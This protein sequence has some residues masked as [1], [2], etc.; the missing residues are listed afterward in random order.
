MNVDKIASLV[1]LADNSKSNDEI[2]SNDTTNLANNN[3]C[4]DNNYIVAHSPTIPNKIYLLPRKR[5]RKVSKGKNHAQDN[6]SQ[7]GLPTDIMNIQS[8]DSQDLQTDNM[9]IDTVLPDSQPDDQS[10]WNIKS[11]INKSKRDRP[12]TLPDFMIEKRPRVALTNTSED[13]S[14]FTDE[15]IRKRQRVNYSQKSARASS[16]GKKAPSIRCECGRPVQPTISVEQLL[17]RKSKK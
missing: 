15:D 12:R 5:A 1:Y 10:E 16:T 7:Q 2:N 9:Q 13:D 17:A 4:N 6:N 14:F 3:Q 11:T 8:D